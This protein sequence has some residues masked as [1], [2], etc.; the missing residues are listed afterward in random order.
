MLTYEKLFEVMRAEKVDGALSKLPDNFYSD[1]TTYLTKKQDMYTKAL[2]EST[3]FSADQSE[4]IL[5]EI[6][7]AKKIV[8]EIYNRREKKILTLALHVART[9]NMNQDLSCLLPLEHTLFLSAV[10]LCQDTRKAT[11]EPVRA[12]QSS[13]V[14]ESGSQTLLQK[15]SY[16]ALDDIPE[17]VGPDLS[18]YGPYKRDDVCEVP[19][20][21]A[22]VLLDR[23]QIKM[24]E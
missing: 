8:Q 14:V 17:F 21:V 19:E 7:N 4:H 15:M 9:A 22:S 1:V 16:V 13:V 20:L 10:R 23:G 6:R 24:V 2:S 12:Q 3:L 5:S 11:F 18:R